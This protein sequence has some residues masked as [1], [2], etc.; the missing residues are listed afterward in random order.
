MRSFPILAVIAGCV[1]FAIVFYAEQPAQRASWPLA[2][3]PDQILLSWCGGDW[4]QFQI[5]DRLPLVLTGGLILLGA[6]A[7][8]RL[9]IR[10][11]RLDEEMSRLESLVFS[12]GIGLNFLSLLMLAIGWCG[13]LRQRALIGGLLGVLIV[14]FSYLILKRQPRPVARPS[15]ATS[16][17]SLLAIVPFALILVLGSLLPPWEFDVREYHLQ[18]PKEWFQAG[19]V[20]LLP[21]N[22]YGNMPLG[23]EMLAVLGMV[24]S[25]GE[26]DWWRGALVGKFLMGSFSLLTALALLAAGQRFFSPR[27]GCV[28]AILYPSIPWV[29]HVSQAGLNEGAVGFYLLLAVVA[30]LRW[31]RGD[32]ARW[33]W[34]AGFFAGATASCKYTGLLFAVAP[35]AVWIALARSASKGVPPIADNSLAGAAGYRG[36]RRTAV[37]RIAWRPV[38]VFLLAVACG[39]SLWYV[40]NFALTGNPVYPLVFG[41]KTRTPEKM[42]Q[43][44]RAHQVPV[45]QHGRRYS[46]DQAFASLA[47]FAWRSEL[48][49]PLLM[50]L[51]ALSLFAKRHQREVR[52]LLALLAAGLA[53]WWLTTH[54]LDRFW[55]PLLPI[56][57]L[58][59]GA[60][61][62]WTDARPWRIFLNAWLA[63]GLTGSFLFL[64]SNVRSDPSLAD[65]HRYF[66]GLETLRRDEPA[67]AGGPSRVNPF[68][69]F[70]NDL[71]RPGAKVLLVGD[72]Q[73]FDLEIPALY[74]TCF[75]DEIFEQL[76]KNCTAAERAAT[77][78]ENGIT[79]VFIHWS[80]IRRYRSPGNYGFSD[81]VTPE[82]IRN[83]FVRDQKLL[84][85][86]AVP[87]GEAI[88]ELFEVV[89]QPP[90][91]PRVRT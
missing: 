83:E 91:Q 43:W 80:D 11:L 38:A 67:E 49:S 26:L 28:A 5:A 78:Q 71:P 55:V 53:I 23:A 63:I 89:P 2:L 34:L 79:H 30:T 9:V 51:A 21:H 20:T 46:A 58:L 1:L 13:G 48:L 85:P 40:K 42:E 31:S 70:L 50:P 57:S 14:S 12:L 86:V 84:R 4:G 81:Y 72:A 35:L 39:G 44:R 36:E 25:P 45:D 29:S 76:F 32:S 17:W 37:Q 59:A 68:H 10:G 16:P 82:L 52:R 60:G 62:T 15:L 75:D 74:S 73:P 54:R 33:L 6:Y 41:G 3:L 88:G 47:Q 22:V 66:V 27:A 65:D 19:R 8:G 90:V 56:A 77:F 7:A 18:V 64:V 69:C 87:G 24:A 61:A